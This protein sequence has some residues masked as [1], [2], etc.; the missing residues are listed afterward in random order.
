ME[1]EMEM[2]MEMEQSLVYPGGI[3]MEHWPNTG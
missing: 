1:L 3:E 2:E